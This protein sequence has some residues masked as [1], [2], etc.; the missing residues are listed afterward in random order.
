MDTQVT[1]RAPPPNLR[2]EF[3]NGRYGIS[4]LPAA[5]ARTTSCRT[6]IR[7]IASLLLDQPRRKFK[8]FSVRTGRPQG[9]C[10][11]GAIRVGQAG[12]GLVAAIEHRVRTDEV[13]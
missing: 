8:S 12:L 11:R 5:E 1:G 13:D 9:S 4:S 10:H 6:D 7:A 2:H 3:V